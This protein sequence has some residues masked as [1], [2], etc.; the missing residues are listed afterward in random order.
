MANRYWEKVFNITSHQANANHNLKEIPP[1]TWKL[2][3]L[4]KNPIYNNMDEHGGVMLT[5][6]NKIEKDQYFMASLLC[7]I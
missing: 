1:H 4:K 2:L 7:E 3:T 5:E 6:I